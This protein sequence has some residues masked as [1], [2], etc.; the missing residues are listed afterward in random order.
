MLPTLNIVVYTDYEPWFTQSPIEP[1]GGL[2]DLEVFITEK[3]KQYVDV[4]FRFVSRHAN[5]PSLITKELLTWAHELWVFGVR[6]NDNSSEPD[7]KLKESEIDLL[8][9]FIRASKGIF[10]TGDHSESEVG[11][12]CED[13][14]HE[15]Y[16]SLGRAL[17][18]NIPIVG[19]FRDWEGPP[20]NCNKGE[21]DKR[22][23]FNTQEGP[24]PCKLEGPTRET[25]E[26]AQNIILPRKNCLQHRLFT[27][28]H[29]SGELRPI[30]KLPDHTHEGRVLDA[31]A[32]RKQWSQKPPKG[33]PE[34][35]PA[36]WPD[37]VVAAIGR[38]KRFP[39]E[40]RIS[41]LVVAFDGDAAGVSRMVADSSFHHYM[42]YNLFSIPHRIAVG[43]R[44]PAPDSDLDQIAHYFGNLAL[45]LAP[46]TIR[47]EIKSQILLSLTR[48]MAVRQV[49]NHTELEVGSVAREVVKRT[50]GLGR[51]QW[52][53]GE[54][55]F[56]ARDPVD[57]FLSVV[58]L[59]D[60]SN[61]LFSQ[62]MKP[63][64]PLGVVLRLCDAFLNSNQVTDPTQI[65]IPQS[66]WQLLQASLIVTLGVVRTDLLN[67]MQISRAVLKNSLASFRESKGEK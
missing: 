48:H 64:L 11:S 8:D 43:S 3:T 6:M 44:V 67:Q 57:Q 63:E 4:K 26:L 55:P 60:E 38:D 34:Q 32:I 49:W 53:L 29:S 30:S 46:K 45:W 37:P 39:D 27:Y 14:K 58:L 12:K 25:D 66:L 18:E 7:N 59:G 5:P 50:I 16:S 41:N 19:L 15:N 54:F 65:V 52:L 23:T 42:D 21:F 2:R 17:G 33:W 62:I 9:E 40:N 36:N 31:E 61:S 20:T 56:E 1:K 24:D 47:D 10:L 28:V 35:W 13:G 22:D 51:L